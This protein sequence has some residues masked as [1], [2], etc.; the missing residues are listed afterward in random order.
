[1]IKKYGGDI[2]SL[3]MGLCQL[4]WKSVEKSDAKN[5]ASQSEPEGIRRICDIPYIDDGNPLHLL[6]VYYPENAD[7]KLPVIIDIH[8]GGWMYGTKELNKI[9][10]LNLAK[11]GYTVFNLS[12]RLVPE[13]TVYE[14]LRDVMS[15][16]E[17]ISLH[18][19]EYPCDSNSIMLTGDSAGGMLASYCAA[20]L[21]SEKLRDVFK[22]ADLGIKLKTLLLTSP[23]ASAKKKGVIGFYTK[24]M[25]GKNYKNEAGYNYM[26]FDEIAPLAVFP[27][28]CLITSS[29]D[30]LG[31]KQTVEQAELLRNKGTETLLL[32]YPKYDGVDLPHVFS[33][34]ASESKAG[35]DAIE[36]ALGFFEKHIVR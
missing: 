7:G 3:F 30:T 32:N 31:L 33:V 18:L 28:T 11:R 12:Y 25:W 6:D 34:L 21:E 27:P 17:Y 14:Q 22:T 35:I 5:I 23:V 1:M 13:V 4:F 9:Y 2:M 20:L 26:N 8:G 16:L 19:E 24:K 29:G 36:K 15:A 10:C